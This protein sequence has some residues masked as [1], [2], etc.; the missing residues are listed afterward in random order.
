MPPQ[1]LRAGGKPPAPKPSGAKTKK[2]PP[3]VSTA[4]QGPSLESIKTLKDDLRSLRE[5]IQLVSGYSV[6]SY[7]ELYGATCRLVI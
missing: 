4:R 7:Q 2:T 6:S 3:P 1:P 5:M